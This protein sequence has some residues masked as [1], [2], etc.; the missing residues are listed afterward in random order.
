[1]TWHEVA[2]VFGMP[3]IRTYTSAGYHHNRW[4]DLRATNGARSNPIV[5]KTLI[6]WISCLVNWDLKLS[7]RR[8]RGG[9]VVD[10]L[11]KAKEICTIASFLR[12]W[13]GNCSIVDK[14]CWIRTLILAPMDVHCEEQPCIRQTN[15]QTNRQADRQASGHA[16][17]YTHRQVHGGG[18]NII[19]ERNNQQLASNWSEVLSSTSH[20]RR[21]TLSSYRPCFIYE[22]V[23]RPSNAMDTCSLFV[24]Y[25]YIPRSAE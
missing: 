8:K 10:G 14:V 23:I 6:R 9:V 22:H 4:A 12:R 15:R 18:G 21:F 1:M 24:N 25:F 16:G 3:A 13:T 5:L 2:E 7:A 17:T 20:L 19:L 11:R